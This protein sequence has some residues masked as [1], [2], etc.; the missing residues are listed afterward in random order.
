MEVHLLSKQNS[1]LSQFIAE[2]RDVSI[3]KDRMRF[4][5]N[6]ERIGQIMA[7]EVSKKFT[8]VSKDVITPLGVHASQQ[9]SQQPVLATI[10]RAGLAMHQGVLSFFDKADCAF[11]SAYRKHTEAH[12]LEIVVEY[13]A[14][15]DLSN[16][17]LLLIDPM[18]ATGQ[19]IEL[20]YK[21]MLKHGTPGELHIL[22]LLASKAGIAYL[23]QKLP[24]ATLWVGDMDDELNA[25]AYIV[26]GLGDAGDLSFGEKL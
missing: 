20:A 21:G 4:R 23:Q 26:P 9:L 22:V 11:I 2:L 1:L 12:D 18:L 5:K 6:I 24:H 13:F 25:N 7:Y 16:R 10:L 8:Y 14:S 3:Q 15:P 19:S 17:T